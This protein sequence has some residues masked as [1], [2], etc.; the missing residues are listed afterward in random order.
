MKPDHSFQ[1]N[2]R[3]DHLL[4]HPAT[5]CCFVILV[6]VA[7][8]VPLAAQQPE[9]MMEQPAGTALNTVASAWG[10]NGK[11][12]TTVPPG[13]TS[14]TAV[15]GGFDHTLALTDGLV[16]GW[17]SNTSGQSTPP[18]GLSG[19]TSIAAGG[20]H[21]MAVRA[22]GSVAL[23][24]SNTHGQLNAPAGLGGVVAVAGGWY[25]SVALKG[26]GTVVSWGDNARGQSSVPASLSGVTRVAAGAYHTLALKGDGTVVAWGYNL[27]GQ[28]TV[29]SGLSGVTAIAAGAYH[30]VA[31]KNDGTVVV[32]GDN[33]YNQRVVPAGL[34]GVVAVAAGA[35]HTLALK[36]NGIV[37]GWG[38][39]SN[40]QT[41][42]PA[43]VT[44]AT[45][46]GAGDSHSLAVTAPAIDF[47]SQNVN[48]TGTARTFTIRNT[49]TAPL[50]ISNIASFGANGG[51]FAVNTSTTSA[52]V[53]AGGSTTFSVAFSPTNSGARKS[54]L[55]VQTN[56]SDE[57]VTV[58]AVSG[59]GLAIAPL[60]SSPVS[61]GITSATASL[62]AKLDFDGGAAITERGFVYSLTSVNANPQIAGAG[63]TKAIVSGTTTGGFGTTISGLS[64]LSG[65]TFKA[66]AINSVGTTY[67]NAA[68]F[69]TLAAPAPEIVIEQ[70]AGTALVN[71]TAAWGL[72]GNGQ[73]TV[74]ASLGPVAAIRAGN[75]HSLALKPD[76][77]V[78]A[79][80]DDS[81]GQSTVPAGLSGVTSISAGGSFNLALKSDGT[82]VAWGQNTSG[83]SSVP[84]GLTGVSAIAAGGFHSLAL[85]SDGTLSYWGDSTYGQLA[86]PATAQSG[87]SA[88][89]A[90]WTHSL[91][92]KTDGTV[93]GW[94][95][96][97]QGQTTVP[98]GLGGVV[99]VAAGAYHS[100]ALK[101]NGTVV[102]WGYNVN[103]QADV[104]AGLNNVVAI[105]A[106]FYFTAA[107][108]SDGTIVAWGQNTN[109]QITTP[110]TLGTVT[111][112]AGGG[113]HSL[114]VRSPVVSLGT[115]SLASTSA[116]VTMT[117][118][119]TGTGPLT[120]TGVS[121]SG[122]NAADFALDTT[123]MVSS[124]PAGGSTGFT[125]SF[126][127]SVS[128]PR[129]TTL[130][131]SSDDADEP[132]SLIA[133]SGTGVTLPTVTTPSST[134]FRSATLGG[135]VA[136]DGGS[137]IT[138]R[139]VV[140]SLAS[141][142]AN[143]QIG[144]VGVTK[145]STSG[146]TGTFTVNTG[147]L[148]AGGSYVFK[149][150]AT[151]ASGTGYSTAASFATAAL[152][153]DIDITR[154]GP[155]PLAQ[156][157]IG[158]G[159]NDWGQA[160]SGGD[161]IALA[162]GA[163]HNVALGRSGSVFAWGSSG[164]NQTKL[165]A[166]VES[167]VIAV[168][169]GAY[170]SLALKSNGTVIA[171][172]QNT[173]G[174]STVP[175]G[176][177][178]VAAIAGGGAFSLVLKNDGTVTGW[179]SN[180][181]G[182]LTIPAG[183]TNV[184]AIAAGS[185]HSVS[186]KSD[187]TVVAW[188]WNASG[189]AAVP[190]GLGNVKA[191][192][193][194]DTHTLA[195]KNDGTIIAWGNNA[196]GQATIPASATNIVAIDAGLHQS[197]ALKS[198]GT[199]IAWGGDA[200]GQ[201]SVPA[202]L[203]SALSVG[204][205]F[206]HSGALR[207]VIDF[208]VTPFRNRSATRDF[209]ITNRGTTTL[210][211]SG[212][213]PNGGNSGDFRVAALGT[214]SI[215]PGAQTTLSL[216][217]TPSALGARSTTLRI[218]SND[219]DE[220]PFDILLRGFGDIEPPK[221]VSIPV[222]DLGHDTATLG[223]EVTGDGGV[224][225]TERGVVFSCTER[226][227]DPYIGG[228]GVVKVSISG[229]DPG[230]FT[231]P[232]GGLA[233]GTQYS[234]RA[235]AINSTGAGYSDTVT[236]TTTNPPAPEVYITRYDG[237]P[238]EGRIVSWGANDA[239][240]LT[241]PS[242]LP[243]LLDVAAGYQ[244]TLALTVSH[245]VI[246]WGSDAEGQLTQPP[247]L[248]DV[249][250]IAAG[251]YHSLV[252]NRDGTIAAWG[253][254]WDGETDVPGDLSGIT[255]IAAGNWHSLAL[256]NDGTVIAWGGS[257]TGQTSVPEGLSNVTSIS[258]GGIHSV[259]LKNDGTV[260]AWGNNDYG[261]CDVP[262]A[263]TSVIA[264][265]AGGNHTLALKNDGTVVAWGANDYGECSV[266]EGLIGV[267]AIAAGL[268]HSVA[269]RADGS[270]VCWG[271]DSSGQCEV[272]ANTNGITKITASFF[273]TVALD[274][275]VD[276]GSTVVGTQS[277]EVGF[278]VYN[279]GSASLDISNWSASNT[280]S[281]AFAGYI[282]MTSAEP[283]EH[284][285]ISYSFQPSTRGGHKSSAA[286]YSNSPGLGNLRITLEGQGVS[287]P[288]HIAEESVTAITQTSATLGA[289]VYTDYEDPV[290]ARGFAIAL[291][292][293][294]ND[295]RIGGAGVMQ[296]SAGGT[297]GAFTAPATSLAPGSGYTFR[298]YATNNS[299]TS[300]TDALAF[301][302]VSPPLAVGDLVF[303]DSNGNG[304]ADGGEGIDGVTIQLYTSAQ[305]PG[306]GTP[307]QT[308]TTANGG[309][310]LIE[311][312]LPGTYRIFI[313]PSM[314]ASSAPL[315]HLRSMTGTAPDTDDDAGEDG[316]D[317]LS[318][319]T[320]GVHSGIFAL[321][322][323]TMPAGASES[324]LY[325][326][327]DDARDA[328]IDLTRD[329]GFVDQT[330]LPVS[331]QQWRQ[332]HGI[333]DGGG[334]NHD[335][336][337]YGDLIEYALGLGADESSLTAHFRV[338]DDHATGQTH[339]ILRRRHGGLADTT[340]TVQVCPDVSGA[341]GGW[342]TT[343]ITPGIMNNGDGT[344]TL[345]FPNVTTDPALA[346]AP[347][348]FA[349][350]LI[351]LD[352]DHDGTP[353]QTITS[354][355]LGWQH[356]ALAT[357]TQTYGLPFVRPAVF[358]GIVDAVNA[359]ALDLTTAAGAT[360]IAAA[361]AAGESYYVEVIAGVNEGHRFEVDEAATTATSIALL[362]AHALSTQ[363]ILPATLA[364]DTIS[365]RP[366]WRLRDAFPPAEYT[367][368]RSNSLA[369]NVQAW[370][371]STGGYISLFLLDTPTIPRRWVRAGDASLA[372]QGDRVLPPADGLF[373]KPRAA[374][375]AALNGQVR[376]WKFACPL[377]IGA[378]LIGNPYPVA[379]SFAGRLMTVASGF[380]GATSSSRADRCMIWTGDAAATAMFDTF[381][382]LRTTTLERWVK[383]SDATLIDQ[384]TNAVF[385]I[386]SAAFINSKVGH[387][388]W[389]IPSPVAP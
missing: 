141:A 35:N 76:G 170:H 155:V 365:L 59:T 91:A 321:A 17:G 280:P 106:G 83:Q 311:N 45:A 240:Q 43:S 142:N 110:P 19:V 253:R 147:L 257:W 268:T 107:L 197:L 127:P 360:S 94:G 44:T 124:V 185:G 118:H 138:E 323:G 51:D 27:Y 78:V 173:S 288:P 307:L 34:S 256:K 192:A 234:F 317:S 55:R 385:T 188:G 374:V 105:A 140:Y 125:V 259:A 99:A 89:A 324:G 354:D 46:I 205:G 61:G 143:P 129:Q 212:I 349:R 296:I 213:S 80:G 295:P 115:Q 202:G 286:F 103:G 174:E 332:Q 5:A 230:V 165:P 158:W 10:Y 137:A 251:A 297:L 161:Y 120:I 299:G 109:G 289:H 6:M 11:G 23:W 92:L 100:V 383:S 348:G 179:G 57:S 166:G 221:V 370:N 310:W 305:T 357:R 306:A 309:R 384:S 380:T 171:W 203:S 111:A 347:R 144:G 160:G 375:I 312:L 18:S 277:G 47:G 241:P 224:P 233:R 133:L 181:S 9:I 252:L 26:D 335:H 369:D 67:S 98:A 39:N 7:A 136:S 214:T 169:A 353:E 84:A 88:I 341:Q 386:G 282:S 270:V 275:M 148:P 279:N 344:E 21:S 153:P 229:G 355:I 373:T 339:I 300:Y 363:T 126:T 227:G 237:S 388:T 346:G 164:I 4:R 63:V 82:V 36:N 24:G 186:L 74:P 102:A 128:G 64:L 69:T 291:T 114:A 211:I 328:D 52:S 231:I 122:G 116:P 278:F 28:T 3:S 245:K 157:F 247:C 108:K 292:A 132:F 362:P 60:V 123:G 75:L 71:S 313:P 379:Q 196:S 262:V 189:Q 38:N 159:N 40:G 168:D 376:T 101:S 121:V 199:V 254:N 337:A 93:V 293:T 250:A 220:N 209:T 87:V 183:L 32:W 49:G 216:D 204:A 301:T 222:A 85:R 319:T 146:T 267:T 246:A 350:L 201:T 172:G 178:D 145:L 387:P 298:A 264:I 314:F 73:S 177:T 382:L 356:R 287:A 235:Y 184:V 162:V 327:S 13:L 352:A 2:G 364:G 368:G 50:T 176:L 167:G 182:Q 226:N 284:T 336:D 1:T 330:A 207:R 276:L 261:Q 228:V 303:F 8:V 156:E 329:F 334:G 97:G 151:T 175:A 163:E 255:A 371:A 200:Y 223:G 198:D 266:P 117:I 308:T 294:N 58:I 86:V 215:A 131:V 258:G 134:V 37:V 271:D 325:G 351:R 236:F 338:S 190:A 29:P 33:L 56:D 72:N 42:I 104:P 81:N 195:L 15:A 139:G 30:S 16:V 232:V 316:E 119:N 315:W 273:D 290:T 372:D 149:A 65:Y 366:H 320:L 150:Y 244:H 302:T 90:G 112:I 389:V 135:T 340:L 180:A 25:H 154:D 20:D 218:L 265:A 210:T 22:D 77:T 66:Y 361:L 239:G 342:S 70:P 62:S 187:G 208:G 68:S 79:W 318:T 238:V 283:G 31:L 367:A 12:Q 53:V 248:H 358:T 217:F 326:T 191:I 285:Q 260:V 95:F 249:V 54:T 274:S 269:L 96:N 333:T 242:P 263:L 381:Y 41:T 345:T 378:N 113:Y 331:F 206:Y 243:L 219:P 359:G 272:P 225:V 194:G 322:P 343:T 14:V 48:S 281:A 152:A 130:R 377:A 193:A 304:R